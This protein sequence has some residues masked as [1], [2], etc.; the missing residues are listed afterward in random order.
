MKNIKI[1]FV[2]I[3]MLVMIIN[4]IGVQK[5]W[6][7]YPINKVNLYDKGECGQLLKKNGVIIR[8]TFV[9]YQ[10]QGKEYPAYCLEKEKPGVG[11]VGEY[12]V[13]PT[14]LVHDIR[15]WRVIVNGYPYQS[16]EKLGCSNEKEAFMATKMAVYST[17]YGY[18]IQDFTPIGEA[19][20][21][22][23]NA[24]SQILKKAGQSQ[25]IK[26][27]PQIE[28][29]AEDKEWKV[30]ENKKV[31]RTFSLLSDTHCK[32][33]EINMVGQV[34]EGTQIMNLENQ[35]ISKISIG[36]KFKIVLDMQQLKEAGKMRLQVNSQME[37]KPIFIGK[38]PDTGKQDYAITGDGYEDS[39]GEIEIAYEKNETEIKIVKQN[40]ETG[41]KLEGVVFQ[42]LNDKKNVIQDSLK[43][44]K[45]GE[46]V[47]NNILPGV[48]YI[49]EKK[50]K[51]GYVQ[52]EEDILVEISYQ[53]KITLKINNTK[54]PKKPEIE[55]VKKQTEKEVTIKKL[56]K[57]GM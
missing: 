39:K 37:T 25:E 29:V 50:P 26:I 46:I 36:E 35:E 13:E 31:S 7:S 15:V 32:E 56:P 4:F 10:N 17:L 21:R 48:Y 41:E 53:E 12:T 47:L 18:S 51:E 6:A 11:E 19:G 22:T 40:E 30:E 3:L 16:P 27:L 44:N 57:T 43:T 24:L 34:P 23:W 38:A 42:F 33:C 2:S 45:E 54:E 14:E 1:I 28:I 8:T 5:A 20:Q 52:L 55:L 49:R 9:V